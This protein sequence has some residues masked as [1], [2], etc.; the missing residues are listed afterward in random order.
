MIALIILFCLILINGLLVMSE[1]ALVSA[2]KA[3]LEGSAA[4]G[5]KK[6]EMALKL[7]KSRKYFYQLRRFS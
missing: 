4:R 3:R 7:R 2:R 6:A 1:I 5:D